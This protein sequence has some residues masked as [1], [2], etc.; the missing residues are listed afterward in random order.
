MSI[1]KIKR[2]QRAIQSI[3]S[4]INTRGVMLNVSVLSV[5]TPDL[6]NVV[7]LAQLNRLYVWMLDMRYKY[8]CIL[9]DKAIKKVM[10][11]YRKYVC[12]IPIDPDSD[13]KS[14]YYY[15]KYISLTCDFLT[16]FNV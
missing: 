5:M 9:S 14:V 2:Y 1:T 11:M 12:K 7:V 13:K 4:V 16:Y 3:D 15:K 8:R 10:C 6:Y